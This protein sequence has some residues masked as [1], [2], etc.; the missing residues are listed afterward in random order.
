MYQKQKEGYMNFMFD[1]ENINVSYI[2]P[3][4]LYICIRATL[5]QSLFHYTHAQ[6]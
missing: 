4:C 1:C 3:V 2:R 5:A 6:T